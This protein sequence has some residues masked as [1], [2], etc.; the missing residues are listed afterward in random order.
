MFII[1]ALVLARTKYIVYF[2]LS[3]WLE[4][5]EHKQSA[6]AIPAAA[7]ELPLRGQADVTRRLAAVRDELEQS[8]ASAPADVRALE[9]AAAALSVACEQLRELSAGNEAADLR[10]PA[11]GA[12]FREK[13]RA[14]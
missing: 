14:A 9:D 10:K 11:A 13:R 3:A 5:L 1:R 7:K 2:L 4:A 12:S 6:R 8:S